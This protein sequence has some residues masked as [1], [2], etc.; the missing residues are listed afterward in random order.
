MSS[1]SFWQLLQ[2]LLAHRLGGLPTSPGFFD[3]NPH[4]VAGMWHPVRGPGLCK[5][6]PVPH[7]CQYHP[8][9]D[10]GNVRSQSGGS[11]RPPF[12]V[13]RGREVRDG[14]V[15]WFGVDGECAWVLVSAFGLEEGSGRSFLTEVG[16]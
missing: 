13:K 15:S 3:G 12:F 11:S 16:E 5:W 14:F 1:L 10:V 6:R 8:F 7:G 2:V 9:T 4:Q